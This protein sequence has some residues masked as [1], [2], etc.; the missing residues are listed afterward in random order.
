ML[1]SVARKLRIFGYDAAYLAHTDDNEVL[2]TG[3]EQDRIILTA[4]K[5][6]FKRIV[7]AGARG[8]LVGG[9]SDLDDMAHILSKLGITS[10]GIKLGARCASCNGTL[11]GRA[12][13]QVKE[14]VPSAVT[15]H[16]DEFYQCKNC[17]KVYWEGGHL[18]RIRDFAGRLER[19]LAS[20]K[21]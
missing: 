17:G 1:G 2:R 15:R 16:H 18:A 3:M 6:L 13:E 10:I 5:E 21:G 11:E 20:S 9:A 14:I 12:P 4:D 8:I 7:K 19:A